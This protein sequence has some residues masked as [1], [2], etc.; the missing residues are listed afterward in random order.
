MVAMMSGETKLQ[1]A[2]KRLRDL[3]MK[4]KRL[5]LQIELLKLAPAKEP[6]FGRPRKGAKKSARKASKKASRKAARR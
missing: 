2:Q 1:K 6:S 3:E 4:H 5:T